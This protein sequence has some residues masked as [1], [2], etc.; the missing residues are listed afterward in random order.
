MSHPHFD[1]ASIRTRDLIHYRRGFK[2]VTINNQLVL[3][4]EPPTDTRDDFTN[5]LKTG[6][7]V[8]TL[9]SPNFMTT[10]GLGPHS[11]Y[12]A[13][14]YIPGLTLREWLDTKPPF[15]KVLH[16]LV[17]ILLAFKYAHER[18]GFTHWNPHCGNFILRKLDHRSSLSYTIENTVYTLKTKLVP[19]AIDFGRS[20]TNVSGGWT[21]PSEGVT[22]TSNPTF[23]L[24]VLLHC[25]LWYGYR[26]EL[27][28]ILSWYDVPSSLTPR[29]T[30][31]QLKFKELSMARF[32]KKC[33]K[34]FGYELR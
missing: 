31:H 1:L 33:R 16:V 28:E 24:Y 12:I 14:E 34:H 3:M 13:L 29:Q 20:Y 17:Q 18:I 7:A 30:V 22:A 25:V 5:E 32:L 6:L 21:I 4:K 19:V 9:K 26:D 15:L 23:D 8:N 11:Q 10:Y 27:H 2:A